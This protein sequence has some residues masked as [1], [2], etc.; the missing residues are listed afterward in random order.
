MAA[1]AVGL[2][3]HLGV[4]RAHIVGASMGGMIAQHVAIE[5][6]ERVLSLTSVMSMTGELEYGKPDPEAAR[7]LFTPPP[8][9]REAFIEWAAETAVYCS[10]RYFD[11]EAAKRK[12]AL[13]FDRSFYPE[14]A[15]RQ[16]AA[17]YASG[18]RTA[19]LPDIKAPT[20]VIHGRD[21]RLIAPSGGERTAALIPGASLYVLADMGHDLPEPL[22]GILVEAITSHA[23]LAV[24]QA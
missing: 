22:W 2:L 18:P 13:A 15:A 1:D 10:R 6:A 21:D 24:T 23:A 5:H 19:T 11:V 9:E 8:K 20:L 7:L 16:L 14:G 4:E 17:V 12:A 3:D